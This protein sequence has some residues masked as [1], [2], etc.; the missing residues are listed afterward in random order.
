MHATTSFRWKI[1]EYATS[2]LEL[3]RCTPHDDVMQH[4]MYMGSFSGSGKSFLCTHKGGN[5]SH[6]RTSTHCIPSGESRP[7]LSRSVS[8]SV[9]A[10]SIRPRASFAIALR[11]RA[12]P[13]K[14][15]NIRTCLHD[16]S[17]SLSQPVRS[18]AAALFDKNLHNGFAASSSPRSACSYTRVAA[19]TEKVSK[20]TGEN[21]DG[22]HE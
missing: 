1:C 15:S 4:C 9:I 14:G 18:N 17:A 10:S 5:E 6:L 21:L 16:S 12:L 20:G 19:C 2:A 3:H 7:S 13:C 8:Q 22:L 11:K